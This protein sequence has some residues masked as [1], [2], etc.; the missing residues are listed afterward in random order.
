[1]FFVILVIS[2][3][4]SQALTFFLFTVSIKLRTVILQRGLVDRSSA[5]MKECLKLMKD[6]W[7]MKS[8]N[9]DPFLLLKFLDVETYE[10]VGES[11]MGALFKAGMVHVQDGESIRQFLGSIWEANAG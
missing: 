4:E 11:V 9:G 3:I 7:L 1:M 5:V 10:S 2:R 6:E 8:C